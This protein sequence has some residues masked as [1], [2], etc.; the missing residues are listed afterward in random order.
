MNNWLP[1]M[2]AAA[3]H[4]QDGNEPR[5]F[6]EEIAR[7]YA[8]L[9]NRQVPFDPEMMAILGSDRADLYEA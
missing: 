6:N 7:L 5:G 2:R 3:D 1:P 4:E 9:L 8:E